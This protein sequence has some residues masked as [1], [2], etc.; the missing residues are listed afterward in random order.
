MVEVCACECAFVLPSSP[1]RTL[2]ARP[3]P[4]PQTPPPLPPI[5]AAAAG[6][7]GGHAALTCR[8]AVPAD[9]PALR[10]ILAQHGSFAASDSLDLSQ[11]VERNVATVVAVDAKGAV[12][13]FASVSDQA[14]DADVDRVLG[15]LQDAVADAV[16]SVSSDGQEN[17]TPP[18]AT[19]RC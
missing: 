6:A 19:I 3:F 10:E 5:M 17:A 8:R 9:V 15:D 18:L 12:V 1:P 14:R 4:S 7:G 16:V 2:R 11:A 13:G